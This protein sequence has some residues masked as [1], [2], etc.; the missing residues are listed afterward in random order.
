VKAVLQFRASPGL[1]RQLAA[2]DFPTVSVDETDKHTFLRE[3][4]DA[5]IL[6]HVLDPVTAAVID[7]A[8]FGSFKRSASGSIRSTSMRRAGAT[9][10]SAICRGPILRQW[11]R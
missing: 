4:R 6:L 11:L 5:D 3:M 2:L 9:L 7:A 10:L 8:V 1:R